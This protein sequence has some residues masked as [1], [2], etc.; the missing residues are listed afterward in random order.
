MKLY[1]GAVALMF[2]LFLCEP[3]PAKTIKVV[4]VGDSTVAEYKTTD[5]LRGWG[6]EI[7]SFLAPNVEVI[8]LALCG[9][10]TK[11]FF[12]TSRWKQAL[13]A[14]PDFVLI[15]FGHN[16]SHDIGQPESTRADED[17]SSNLRRYISEA[18]AAGI[19]P[20]LVTPMHRRQFYA[21]GQ[22]SQELR[23]YAE[24]MIRVGGDLSVPVIDLY[25]VSGAV[26]QRLGEKGTSQLTREND[27]THFTSQGARLMAFLVARGVLA[28]VEQARDLIVPQKLEEF[29]RDFPAIMATSP[30]ESRLMPLDIL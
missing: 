3:M 23:A 13:D 1:F 16:D 15:Q 12:E 30:E 27:R 14:T 8:N 29:K 20:I 18:R 4:L 10:S 11:T 6:Q 2:A 21:D 17:Y 26:F 22:P 25:S 7:G 9:A 28:S 5:V 19:F 24:A